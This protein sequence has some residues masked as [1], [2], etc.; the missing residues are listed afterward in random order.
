MAQWVKVPAAK[1]DDQ[2]SILGTHVVG[3][4]TLASKSCPLTS[5]CPQ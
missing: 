3:E 5:I 4:S 1:P 2:S